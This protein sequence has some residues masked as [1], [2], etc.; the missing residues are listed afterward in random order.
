MP[1][2]FERVLPRGLEIEVR[3]CFS[4]LARRARF[5]SEGVLLLPVRQRLFA[6]RG[7]RRSPD[8]SPPSPEVFVSSI[9]SKLVA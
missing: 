2:K 8:F 6:R 3:V 9:A 5:C 4:R 7:V 1:K